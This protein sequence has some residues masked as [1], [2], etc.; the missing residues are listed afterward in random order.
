MSKFIYVFTEA[1]RDA[2]L[3]LGCRLLPCN[4]EQDTYVLIN[5]LPEPILFS[6]TGEIKF[7]MSDTLL[8]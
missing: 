5:D 3:A 6:K 7:S 2:L 8:F 1:D 4:T